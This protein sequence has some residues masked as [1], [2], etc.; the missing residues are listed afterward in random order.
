MMN[1]PTAALAGRGELEY[2]LLAA[3]AAELEEENRRLEEALERN[4]RVFR[5]LL[6]PGEGGITLTAP[7]RRIVRVIK[8]VTGVDPEILVGQQIESLVAAE[9]RPAVIDAYQELLE[10]RRGKVRL[11]VRVPDAEGDVALYAATLTDM[12]DNADIQG[13]VCSYSRY[14]LLDGTG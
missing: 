3:R 6:I 1:E 4:A 10:K 12:L 13:I 11:L 8:G 2:E 5:Q 9:D 7:D 14:S